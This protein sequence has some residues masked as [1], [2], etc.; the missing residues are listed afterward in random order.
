[1]SL[2]LTLSRFTPSSSVFIVNFEQ[3]NACWN[4][5]YNKND[6]NSHDQDVDRYDFIKNRETRGGGRGNL[7]SK[8]TLCLFTNKRRAKSKKRLKQNL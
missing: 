4:D 8:Y 7:R 6:N 3:I 2:L 1:M 5:S